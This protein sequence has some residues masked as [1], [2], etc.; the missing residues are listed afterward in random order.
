MALGTAQLSDLRD[1]LRARLRD[2]P[3]KTELFDSELTVWL[4]QSVNSL[5]NILRKIFPN[6]YR[7]QDEH[8][9]TG[10]EDTV[11]ITGA[12]R[13]ESCYVYD[14]SKN[15]KVPL[16]SPDAFVDFITN[17]LYD[18]EYFGTVEQESTVRLSNTVGTSDKVYTY[19]QRTPTVM[20][21]DTDAMDIP[22]EYRDLVVKYAMSLCPKVQ[23]DPNLDSSV[24]TKIRSMM[25]DEQGRIQ[26]DQAKRFAEG[27]SK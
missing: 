20:S 3:P 4:N 15:I 12:A 7:A 26:L 2:I 19:Y 18:S 11:E 23:T 17:G 5:A 21:G 16:F 9:P 6:L 25:A 27:E 13:I 14:G 24:E 22:D 1:D 8:V 10:D